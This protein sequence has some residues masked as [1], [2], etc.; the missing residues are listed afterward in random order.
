MALEQKACD[1]VFSILNNKL[2]QKEFLL[3]FQLGIWDG[4]SA[5]TPCL[6]CLFG[7]NIWGSA[8]FYML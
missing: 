7:Q 3:A 5:G 1:R 6:H 2:Y 4:Y 8:I